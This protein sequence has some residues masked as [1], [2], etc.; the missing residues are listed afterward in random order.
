M[1]TAMLTTIFKQNLKSTASLIESIKVKIA[2]ERDRLATLHSEHG[3]AAL[4]AETGDNTK[5]KEIS[6]AM[7]LKEER[8][9]ELTAALAAAEKCNEAEIAAKRQAEWLGKVENYEKAINGFTAQAERMRQSSS[10]Y[11]ED[12]RKLVDI[13]IEV[14]RTNPT[15]TVPPM[16]TIFDA[17]PLHNA[18]AREL[19]RLQTP[20]MG[21]R[22]SERAPGSAMPGLMYNPTT[23]K[24]LIDVVFESNDIAL[25]AAKKA[26]RN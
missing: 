22:P 4:D 7:A 26:R 15:G 9:K 11:V 18:V 2:T 20:R 5:L 12:Y 25:K 19:A 13:G 24:S 8:I 6:S 23:M 17:D 14:I 3:A 21:E 1:E 10:R 16:G